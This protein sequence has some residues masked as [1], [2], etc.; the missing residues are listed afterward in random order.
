[1]AFIRIL[2]TRGPD[3]IW[4]FYNA[5]NKTGQEHL[6]KHLEESET[7]KKMIGAKSA[8]MQIRN[9]SSQESTSYRLDE[10]CIYCKRKNVS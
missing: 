1:M 6:A 5:L 10:I 2:K 7:I 9:S 3:A 4:Q 8:P